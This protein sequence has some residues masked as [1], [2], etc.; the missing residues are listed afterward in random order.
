MHLLSLISASVIISL[1]IVIA[2][3][4]PCTSSLFNII[5]VAERLRLSLKLSVTLNT[6]DY[7]NI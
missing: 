1:K 6:Y 3:L 7:L 4:G 2:S 5:V